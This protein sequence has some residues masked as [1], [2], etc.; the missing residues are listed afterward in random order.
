MKVS[1]TDAVELR[2]VLITQIEGFF[3]EQSALGVPCEA[4]MEAIHEALDDVRRE[5]T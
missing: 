5:Q 1:G 2:S 3:E 4:I